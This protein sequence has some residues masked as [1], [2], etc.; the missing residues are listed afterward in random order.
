MEPGLYRGHRDTSPGLKRP[1][2][3]VKVHVESEGFYVTD[4]TKKAERYTIPFSKGKTE[5]Q[6]VEILRGV[7]AEL[8]LKRGTIPYEFPEWYTHLITIIAALAGVACWG[9][10][11]LLGG[12]WGLALGWIAMILVYKFLQAAG[13][14]LGA[15]G[16]AVALAGLIIEGLQKM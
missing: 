2:G 15:L 16:A 3:T 9:L 12:F 14:V 1:F 8:V 11:A 7:A 10:I 5:D 13:P 4:E 6:V